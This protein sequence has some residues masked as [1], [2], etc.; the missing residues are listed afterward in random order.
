MRPYSPT[1]WKD[2]IEG[3]AMS[4]GKTI[5]HANAVIQRLLR[6]NENFRQIKGLHK[7]R[8]AAPP[9]AILRLAEIGVEL[10]CDD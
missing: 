6:L 10:S 3:A 1:A 8:W 5:T 9:D 7:E 2:A 4:S